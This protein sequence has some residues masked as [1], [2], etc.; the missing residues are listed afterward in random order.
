LDGVRTAFYEFC[1]EKGI[2][3]IIHTIENSTPTYFY[4]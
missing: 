2:S 4:K 1:E 3:P